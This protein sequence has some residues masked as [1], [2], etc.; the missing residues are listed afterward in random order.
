MSEEPNNKRRWY[1]KNPSMARA[2][3][4]LESFP[5]EFHAVVA[6]GIMDLTNRE[7]QAKE[8][9]KGYRNLGKEKILGLHKSQRKLRKSDK[10]PNVHSAITHLYVLSP[11]SQLY[12][13]TLIMELVAF[14]SEYLQSCVRFD[15]EPSANELGGIVESYIE[16][17]PEQAKKLMTEIS[18]KMKQKMEGLGITYLAGDNFK[19][20]MHMDADSED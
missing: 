16:Q 14:V 8:V 7:F 19:I 9:V 3:G 12:M 6:H 18:K 10:N 2:L 1:D 20:N 4:F 5:E 11:D 13:A 15:K 17:G